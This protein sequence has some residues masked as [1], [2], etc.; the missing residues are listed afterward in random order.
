LTY[1]PCPPED[2]NLVCRYDFNKSLLTAYNGAGRMS[3]LGLASYQ[4]T[5]DKQ[6]GSLEYQDRQD[7]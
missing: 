1:R 6:L 7:V 3:A 5:P 2:F 4:L